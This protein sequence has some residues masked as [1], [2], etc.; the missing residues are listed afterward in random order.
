MLDKDTIVALA[1]S[2]GHGAI[3]VIR[4]SGSEAFLTLSK[5]FRPLK[6]GNI[7]EKITL[8]YIL[9]KEERIDQ[10]LATSFKA[11]KSYTGENLVEVSCHG[12][13][14]VVRHNRKIEKIVFF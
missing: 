10:V 13:L 3:A 11:P 2:D 12:S 1:T 9:D 14:P 8:G 7:K 5:I 6:K 4:I